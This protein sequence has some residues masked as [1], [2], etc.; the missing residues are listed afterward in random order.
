MADKGAATQFRPGQSGNPGGRPRIADSVRRLAGRRAWHAL[1]HLL[2]SL[3][4]N[5]GII[6]ID[7]RA[8][9]LQA[10]QRAARDAARDADGDSGDMW[11]LDDPPPAPQPTEQEL[12]EAAAA[13]GRYARRTHWTAIWLAEW[14]RADDMRDG[15]VLNG[16]RNIHTGEWLT[17]T[18]WAE[19]RTRWVDHQM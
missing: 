8:V 11:W 9:Q 5:T 4:D 2:I 16:W 14:V 18:R 13:A 6:V 17:T 15:A 10:G 3:N 19:A 7:A 1:R 12:A